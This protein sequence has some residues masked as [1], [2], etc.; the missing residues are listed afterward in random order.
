MAVVELEVIDSSNWL[1]AIDVRVADDQVPFVA[2]CQ[3]VALVIL[4]KCHLRPDG[5]RWEPFLVRSEQ[6]AAVGVLAVS[7]G[8]DGCEL[9]H[10]AI[11]ERW[12]RRGLGT[13][14]VHAVI[15]RL[16]PSTSDC[17]HLVVTAHPDNRAAHQAYRSAG[18]VWSGEKRNGE[19]VWRYPAG[20][21]DIG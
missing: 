13:A 5:R 1:E 8:D 7:H 11:D 16:D 21:T 9:R 18:F 10:V 4:A 17:E 19:P 2:D 15:D 14:A 12:Q 20:P 3:P 6:G